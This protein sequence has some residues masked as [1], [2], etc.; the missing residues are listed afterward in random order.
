MQRAVR[1]LQ[2]HRDRIGL[3][4]GRRRYADA[5]DRNVAVVLV[6]RNRGG[7]GRNRRRVGDRSNGDRDSSVVGRRTRR[8]GAVG[9]GCRHVQRI[10]AL[11]L[12]GGGV[13]QRGQDIVDVARQAGNRHRA[14]AVGR[15]RGRQ[16]HAAI[17]RQRAVRNLQRH[18]DRIG[19]VT[20]SRRDADARDRNI[21][22][23]LVQRDR[24]GS[25]GNRWGVGNR[26]D[27]DRN[28]CL[29]GS[30]ARRRTAVGRGRCHMQ[31]VGALELAVWRI[32]QAGEEG[33]DVCGRPGHRNGAGAIGGNIG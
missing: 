30:R 10:R 25:R 16:I 22:V 1:N 2:R 17:K 33:V 24:A 15:N 23:V 29:R 13:F 8:C 18:R 19:R 4:A 20:F 7:G 28:G 6:Q 3:V 26:I 11:E 9:R 5:R 14:R 31:R 12:A 32:G 27:G 21:A